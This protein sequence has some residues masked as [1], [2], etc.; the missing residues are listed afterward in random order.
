MHCTAGEETDRLKHKLRLLQPCASYLIIG[1]TSLIWTVRRPLTAPSGRPC[2]FPHCLLRL[3]AA[4][5]P[6]ATERSII[7]RLVSS[8]HFRRLSSDILA[9]QANQS[10]LSSKRGP[11]ARLHLIPTCENRPITTF[12]VLLLLR[13]LAPA[14]EAAGGSEPLRCCRSSLLRLP[15]MQRD[16]DKHGGSCSGPSPDGL[17]ASIPT[18][19]QEGDV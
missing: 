19:G 9:L 11:V 12:P 6:F 13:R 8:S 10:L 17:A 18:A 7:E 1:V 3:C 15:V 4:H 16:W 2:N 5:L 14:P